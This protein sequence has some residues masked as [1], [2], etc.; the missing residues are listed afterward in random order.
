MRR[1]LLL[2][3]LTCIAHIAWM[4]CIAPSQALAVQ[5]S[6]VVTLASREAFMVAQRSAII[7]VVAT[8]ALVP[9]PASLAI[10]AVTGPVGWAS[11]GLAA[12]VMIYQHYYSASDLAAIK[13]AAGTA[14]NFDQWELPSAG[15]TVVFPG[16]SGGA[17]NPSFPNAQ[18]QHSAHGHCDTMDN[19]FTHDWSVGPFPN[20]D[21]F[22]YQGPSFSGGALI[23]STIGA[24]GTA[25]YFF[26]HRTGQAGAPVA[27]TGDPTLTDTQNYMDGL[28]SGDSKSIE[29]HA[30]K[31]GENGSPTAAT[32][33]VSIPATPS[34]IVSTV[35]DTASIDPSDVVV[36][37]GVLPPAG[38]E[39]EKEA[40]QVVNSTTNEETGDTTETATVTCISGDCDT[41]TIEGIFAEHK[42]TWLASGFLSIFTTLQALTWPTELGSFTIDLAHMGFGS[43]TVDFNDYAAFF[44]A[45][46]T[47]VIFGA[48]WI[49]YRM[50][51]G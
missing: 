44:T 13:T 3:Y 41:R 16:H 19:S 31:G 48:T 35:K 4:F 47:F 26:C 22:F 10:R 11:L 43:H 15:G 5:Y 40:T 34:E 23:I 27:K 14:A 21:I 7:N 8:N 50:I 24:V 6:R 42:D 32:D 33:N 46:R 39:T 18:V 17:V 28:S 38:T 9:S 12:G 29:T 2:G 1:L 20:A 37:S 30:Q 25:K 51:L 45:L 49:G 36:K